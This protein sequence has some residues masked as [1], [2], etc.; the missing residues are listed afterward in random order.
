[1]GRPM[2]CP[3]CGHDPMDLIDPPVTYEGVFLGN[4]R[5]NV[6]PECKVRLL[7]QGAARAMRKKVDAEIRKRRLRTV[8]PL[9]SQVVPEGQS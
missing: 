5:M 9:L 1:M 4:Y 2:K 6:C 8:P 3:E 7:S